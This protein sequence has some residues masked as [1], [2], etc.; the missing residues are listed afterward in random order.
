VTRAVGRCLLLGLLLASCASFGGRSSGVAGPIAWRVDEAKTSGT[1]F[2]TVYSFVLVLTERDGAPVTFWR[3]EKSIWSA[4]VSGAMGNDYGSWELPAHGE[5]R[6]PMGARLSC[7][8]TA[9]SR[10]TPPRWS[11]VLWGRDQSGKE[12]S[13]PM[14]IALPVDLR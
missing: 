13:L 10:P 11:V 12:L 1:S 8:S 9:C 7:W 4:G 5:L 14:E 3:I 2:N 6:L